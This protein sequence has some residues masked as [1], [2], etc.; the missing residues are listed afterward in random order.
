M[1]AE[2]LFLE[3]WA[4]RESV[5]AGDVLR[6]PRH[7]APADASDE[8]FIDAHNWLFTAR[9]IPVVYYGSEIG[10][11]RGKRRARWQP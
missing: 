1:L 2:R 11:T 8:G 10:F 5:R 6:Q 9:G 7:G 4:V 3:R